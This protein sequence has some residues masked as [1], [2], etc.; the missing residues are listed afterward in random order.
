M[1]EDL[2]RIIL[3]LPENTLGARDA[4]ML[5]LGFTGGFRRAELTSLKIEDLEDNGDGLKVHLR[6]VRADLE[7]GGRIVAI[8]SA[9]GPEICPVR[10]YRHWIE[11]SGITSGPVFPAVDR[12]GNIG[13]KSITPQVVG[14]VVKRACKR[15]GLDPTRFGAGSLRSGWRLGGE[16]RSF[17]T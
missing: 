10:R 7:A 3:S 4:A 6:Q 12:H 15:I 17:G 13:N 16:A 5:L 11:V 9:A 8:P 1:T 2:R 14:L